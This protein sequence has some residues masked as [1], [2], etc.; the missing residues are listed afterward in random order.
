MSIPTKSLKNDFT[1]PEFGLGTWKIGG[2]REYDPNN[3]D[4]AD[5]KVIQTAVDLG[6]TH[7][8]TAESYAEGYAE[9][10]VGQAIKKYERKKLFITSKVSGD[11]LSYT[12]V[13]KACQ[14]SLERLQTPYLDL[15]LIHRYNPN[16]SLKKTIKALDKLAAEGLIKNIGVS[17]FNTAHLQ[18]I[19][20]YTENKIVCNQV[21]YNL[22][23]REPEK[24][25]LLEYCQN[26]DV[27]L[28]A[29]RP[30]KEAM[31]LEEVPDIIKKLGD[32][33]QKTPAQIAL[34]W[35]ISQLNVVTISKTGSKEHLQD[36]LGAVGWRM[37]KE[38]IEYLRKK[39][40]NQEDVSDVVPLG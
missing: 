35:L 13:L 15:Y 19:Q 32:K 39:F 30:L 14:Q 8:D 20:S 38:D 17:N 27:L 18:E 6:V 37:D 29:W 11:N 28:M 16:F 24:D 12:Q 10:L 34:N 4:E 25:G 23:F 22:R 5:I 9:K 26:N 33:Y 31:I 36:N 21:H 40:P 3:D 2:A 7:I 1:I